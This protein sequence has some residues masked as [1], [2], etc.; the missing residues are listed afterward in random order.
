MKLLIETYLTEYNYHFSSIHDI[1][2][3]LKGDKYELQTNNFGTF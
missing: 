3:E 2:I 1:L